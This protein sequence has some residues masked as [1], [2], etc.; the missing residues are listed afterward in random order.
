MTSHLVRILLLLT[1]VAL[2]SACAHL[3]A[4][5]SDRQLDSNHGLR[6]LGSR[7]EDG[8]IE[9]KAWINIRRMPSMPRNA[10]VVVVSWDGQVLL[11]GQTPDSESRVLAGD[12]TRAVRHVEQVHNE[13]HIGPR[14]GLLP[15]M[16][17]G[18]I[19]L[20]VK[21][22]LLFGPDIPGRRIKVVTE[23]G[24]VYLM[25]L[26]DHAD[27]ARAVEAARNVYGVQKIVKIFEYLET[28]AAQPVAA[29][30]AGPT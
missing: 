12:I 2:T 14:I 15:R 29:G 20:R 23:N 5:L 30:G 8:A 3:V 10:R 27:A 22:R 4:P 6:T 11:A 28:P 21:S 9:R 17:D 19:T 1:G 16:H 18:W 13:M 7:I 26:L 25:G 24:V